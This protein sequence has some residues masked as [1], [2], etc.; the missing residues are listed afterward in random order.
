[1]I[2]RH[3]ASLTLVALFAAGCQKQSQPSASESPSDREALALPTQAQP[4][5]PT[6]KVWLGAEEMVAEM[7][8]T[9]R[10]E[11]TGMMFRTNLDENA[12]MI[13]AFPKPIQAAF[14][15]KNCPLPLSVAYIDPSG[16]ILEIRDLQPQDTNSV[17]AASPRVQFVLEA[18]RGWFQRHN[19]GPGTLVRTEYGSMADTFLSRRAAR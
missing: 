9:P 14:W 3:F 10:Q 12:G 7:A 11:T 1:M 2:F 13:F 6:L 16:S 15:M 4:K 5:L 19:I 17:I 18:N 8:L